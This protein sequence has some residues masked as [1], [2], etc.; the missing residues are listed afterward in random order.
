[1]KKRE[2]IEELASHIE[3][4]AE[5]RRLYSLALGQIS[6]LERERD[7][8]RRDW[9]ECETVR[10]TLEGRIKELEGKSSSAGGESRRGG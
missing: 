5:T 7:D 3:S 10:A 6:R 4:L 2:V 8:N 1:M 9:E